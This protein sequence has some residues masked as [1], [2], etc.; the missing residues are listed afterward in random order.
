MLGLIALFSTIAIFLLRLFLQISD[1][2]KIPEIVQLF[3]AASLRPC[4][5]VLQSYAV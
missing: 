1:L 5:F 3:F 4:S 2:A